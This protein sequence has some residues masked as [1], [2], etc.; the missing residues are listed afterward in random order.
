V[1]T[2]PRRLLTSSSAHGDPVCTALWRRCWPSAWLHYTLVRSSRG[3]LLVSSWSGN[4]RF[5]T[6]RCS[7]WS[8][9]RV[10][11]PRVYRSSRG[12]EIDRN[13]CRACCSRRGCRERWG[14]RER[15][16]GNSAEVCRCRSILRARSRGRCIVVAS[17]V[18]MAFRT[19]PWTGWAG[20][21]RIRRWY[22]RWRL[23][24]TWSA[25]RMGSTR[26][27]LCICSG[28][29][30]LGLVARCPI[31]AVYC[32]LWPKFRRLFELFSSSHPRVRSFGSRLDILVLLGLCFLRF[33]KIFRCILSQLLCTFLACH[34]FRVPLICSHLR[35]SH[36]SMY[37]WSFF[38]H[39][40]G[41]RCI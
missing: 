17:C 26:S 5:W 2:R 12:P 24:C 21:C 10:R 8:Y 6:C 25:P 35:A 39:S 27:E 20:C 22:G 28:R 30:W 3:R 38:L 34:V 18:W 33:R 31:R 9:R 14:R 40:L 32:R 16:V 41:T 29:F 19:C 11:C 36:R 37:L 4:Q 1:A 15:C 7:V 13:A 23:C